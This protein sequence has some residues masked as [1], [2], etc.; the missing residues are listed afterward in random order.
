MWALS[1]G[2]YYVHPQE[3]GRLVE[4]V[5]GDE[6]WTPAVLLSVHAGFGTQDA[7]KAI[8]DFRQRDDVISD[9]FTSTLVLQ[10][11]NN[12]DVSHVAAQLAQ[13]SFTTYTNDPTHT[14]GLLPP[15]PYFIR[16]NSIHQAWKLYEDHLDAF[17]IPT[18]ADDVV[19]PTSFSVLQ[20][21]SQ[22]GS[23]RSVAVPSRL[24]SSPSK[25]KPLA[26]ARISIKDNYDLSGIRTTMMNRAY[27]E[28]YPARSSS[29]DY[30]KKLIGLGA[31]IVGKT[32]MSAFASAEEPTDQWI[33][34]HCPFNPRG[35]EYQTPSCSSTG[36][37]ASLAG[38]SWLDHSIGTDTSGS[39]RLP[40]AFN[41]LFGL[42]TS[43]GVT[44]R[45]G[46]VPSC[47]EF[48][49]V[50]TLHRSLKD[51]KHL[52]AAT[53]DVPDSS[54]FP[55]RLLYP[56]DFFPQADADQQAMTESF[57]T[58]VES[59]LGIERT[60]IS[61]T[62]TWASNPPDEAQGKSLQDFL[63]MSAVWPMY[64]DTYHTFDAFRADYLAKFGKEAFVGPYMRKRWSIAVP[65][66]KEERAQGVAEMKIFRT[67]FEANIMGQHNDTVT[68]AVMVMPF[69]SA[70]P[71]YRDDANKLPSIVGSF[72]VFYLP[73]VLQLPT[74][75]IP[76]G[77]KPY[78]SRISGLEEHLPIVSSFMGAKGS[79]L[80][81]INLAEAALKSAKWPTEVQTGRETFA[82]GDDA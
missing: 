81:L 47:N 76:I 48:D 52:T 40:A 82:T 70:S 25:E 49:T 28:L 3:V 10:P 17:V 31:V 29:A 73:A 14:L 72:S 7:E 8:K 55:K 33:D 75:I 5:T 6:F 41:G 11:Q 4:T 64:Y 79:D 22:Q 13:S 65:F 12:E 21:V 36:A 15:G 58:T 45:Q 77:Q 1:R 16:G 38:Y 37:G 34:Y 51:A 61:I 39:I 78:S 53:L 69:G 74:L 20:A 23:F 32:K 43:Y 71:K 27:N 2:S 59:F 60:P 54:R 80:M 35:D 24:Y 44:S 18:I 30:V 66:T 68:D 62:D 57:I 19:N 9:D 50:G 26:G 42:R 46:I 56:L 67:W 63:G